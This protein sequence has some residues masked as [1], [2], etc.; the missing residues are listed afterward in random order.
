MLTGPRVAVDSVGPHPRDDCSGASTS[1]DI[2][3][4]FVLL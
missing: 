2:L 1:V 3:V 4:S